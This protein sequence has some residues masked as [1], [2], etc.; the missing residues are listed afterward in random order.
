MLDITS[1]CRTCM[2]KNV[3]LID[4][5]ENVRIE[6]NCFQLTELLVQCTTIQVCGTSY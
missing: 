1:S 4:I 5:T 2:K 3:T 6:E